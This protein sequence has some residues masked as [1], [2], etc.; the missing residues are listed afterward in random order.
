MNIVFYFNS[1][2]IDLFLVGIAS[3]AILILGSAVF[4]NNRKSVTHRSFLALSFIAVIYISVNYF[5]YRSASP[6]FILWLLRITIFFAAWHSF[7]AFQ[8]FFVFPNEQQSTPFWYKFL[9]IPIVGITSLLTLTP[10]VFSGLEKLAPIGEVSKASLAPG[11]IIFGI[12]ISSLII[13]GLYTLLKKT[14]TAVGIEKKR[15]VL[16]LTGALLTYSLLIVFNFVLPVVFDNQRFIS[17]APIFNL[18]FIV[19]T[20]YA[21]LR[22]RLLNTKIIATEIL[23]FFLL[24]STFSQILFV[25]TPLE[26]ILRFGIFGGLLAFSILLIRSVRKEVQQRE[27]M[28]AMALDLARLNERLQELDRLKS[29]FI[30]MAGHQLRA[31]MTVIKGYISL[32]LEDT[33][34]G[35]PPV[36][37]E[38]LGKAM[39]STGQLIKLVS[40]LL[41]LSRIEAGKIKYEK[42]PGDFGVV[43][44]EVIDGFRQNAEKKNVKIV[45]DNRAGATQFSFDKDKMREVAVN[46]I[47]NA[48]KYSRAG[49]QARVVYERVSDDGKGDRVRLSVADSG[50]GMKPV[51][52]PKLF[53]K[54]SRTDEA[55]KYDPNGMGI[56][57]YFVKRVVEDHGGKVGAE[58]EGIGKGSTFWVEMPI[59]V[60]DASD[61]IR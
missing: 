55:K 10:F 50:L 22:Y 51:D 31:P 12:V 32:V 53:D 6:E 39:F 11:V 4:F 9:L 54:F 34:K 59:T 38:A 14:I 13:G 17:L 15:L 40:S 44:G 19:F 5:N 42:V 8:L 48:I 23:V 46:L 37:K 58:S 41:D 36:V 33:I 56:G 16:M 60:V 45:F 25:K 1:L 35:A 30:S 26:I 3:A 29:E 21:I 2:N 7:S 47:D 49:G 24:I 61:I 18:P 57:L 43:I 27:R 52:I 20:G 28:Q